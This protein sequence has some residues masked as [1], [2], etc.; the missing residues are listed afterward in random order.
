MVSPQLFNS[1]SLANAGSLGIGV[2]FHTFW[3]PS[4]KPTAL[5]FLLIGREDTNWLKMGISS[6]IRADTSYRH[7]E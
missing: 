1:L 6:G 5:T 2:I 7:I 4:R 3:L